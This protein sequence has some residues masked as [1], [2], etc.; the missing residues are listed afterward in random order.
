M[1]ESSSSANLFQIPNI[2]PFISIKLDGTNYLQWT[3][4]FLPILRSYDLLSIVDGSEVC[5][6]KHLVTAEG[7]QDA[8][9]AY[10]LWNKKDQ[11]VL[12]WLI[13]TLTPNV[14]ST[15]YGLNT[16]R[17]V[18]NS[19]ATRY[20]SQ[21]KSR[22]AHLK[23]Q[24]QTLRQESRTC[25]EY[26][27]LAKSWAD[28]LAAVGKPIDD[29]DLISFIISGL[30]PSYNTFIT[31]FNFA[32]RET[33]LPYDD[34]EAELLNHE[35]LLE[36]QNA[37][38]S[39]DSNTFALYSNKQ[40][41]RDRKPKFNGPQK[42]N[43][44]PKPHFSHQN[45]KPT[46][47][48]PKYKPNQS[49]PIPFNSSRPP[50][51]I[52]GK[53]N[54]QAL[55]C[56]HRMDY[57]YQGRHPPTQLA[58]M[59][60]HTNSQLVEEDHQPWYADSGANQHITADL[61]NLNLSSEPYQGNTDVAVGNGS[62]L[63]IQNTGSTTLTAQNSSFKL[64]TVLHCPDVPV[65]LLSIQKFCEENDCLFQL[66]A[67]SFLVK[68]IRTGQV[69][70]HG[71][72]RDGLYPIPLQRLSIRKARGLTAFLGIQTSASVWHHRLGHP[73]MV[74]VHRVITHNKLPITG[75]GDKTDFCESCQLA[76]C[77]RLPFTK[78][79]RVSN[80]PLQLV[81]SDVWQSPVVS[82]S[83]C[84]YYVIF[85]D[86]Y[87]RFSWLFP[88]K[89]KSDVY[90]CFI[91]FKC[92]VENLFSSKI[93]SFQSDGG[94]EYS[95]T[96]FKNL[97]TQHGIFH[98][99][100]C[101]HTSPQNGVAERKHRHVVDTGLALLAHSGLSTKYWVDAFLTAIYLI[102]RLPTPTISNQTPYYKLFHHDPDYNILR[103]FGCA[104]FPLMRPYNPHK[105]AFRSKK[106]IFLGYSSNHRGYRCLDF[107]TNRVYISRDVVFNEQDFPAKTSPSL[108]VSTENPRLEESV[109][110]PP[111]PHSGLSPPSSPPLISLTELDTTPPSPPSTTPTS[112]PPLPETTF[113]S[114][115]FEPPQDPPPTHRMIT[116]SMTGSTRPKSFR[117]HQLYYSTS[118]PLKAF[119][120]SL[121]PSEPNTYNQASKQPEWLAAMEAEFG[122]LT[123]NGTWS[124][125]PRPPNRKIIRNK[126]VFRLK[127]KADG[128]IDRYKARLVAK[129]FDQENGIDYTETFS[130][131]IKPTTIRV[132]LALAVHFNWPIRQLDVSNA[133]LHGSLTEEV[134]M[135]QPRGFVDPHFPNHVCRLH[136][137]LYGLKQAPRAW[138]TRLRQS[139]VHLG[140][141]ESLVDASLFTFHHSSIHL[142]VLIYV[143]D[144][145]VTGTHPSHMLTVIQQLQSEFPLKDLGPLSYFLGIHAVRDSHGLHLSQ[146]KYIL[147]L[148]NRARMVG[149]KPSS[150]PTASGSKLSQHAGTPLP[151]GTEYR[152][153][154]GALQYCTLTRPDIAFSV[155]QLCQFMHSPTSAHWTAAKRVLRYLK[156]TIEHG[157]SFSHSSLQ[158]TAFCDSDW[159]GNP[160]DRRSTTGF[161]IFLGSCLVSWSAKKQTVVARSST[162]AEYRAMAVT[163]ADL[164]WIRML[165]QDLH[166]PLASPPT[167]WCDNVGALAL[168][169]NPVFHA[170]TKHIEVD[171]H[172]IRE[173]VANKDMTIR[174]ISTGDQIADIFTKGLSTTRFSFLRAKL[175]V[176]PCPISLRGA[177]KEINTIDS[178]TDTAGQPA[179]SLPYIDPMSHKVAKSNIKQG[180]TVKEKQ[181]QAICQGIDSHVQKMQKIK[182]PS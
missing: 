102:N 79:D 151:D 123:T 41:N 94:G 176:I 120:S 48:F 86:D 122:A 166:V 178:I 156:G 19:L 141:V 58:A 81:H 100:S 168:A 174:F 5:P 57:S 132:I 68:D 152:Q 98:R 99:F 11:L 128:S 157:L 55:D 52:C 32:T 89:S 150:T 29:D 12:S 93:K 84:R 70:L 104:C 25:S 162:E 44:P 2:S 66:T 144:I 180:K 80:L 83:G 4:Q 77:K 10:V 158:L 53:P 31:T 131:V 161:G 14:L 56:Y 47:T 76:K 46:T 26:L 61:E 159:A 43:H 28:Q 142:Y 64:N 51:Q 1:A 96:P 101:P 147:E 65:N 82:L 63:Q 182:T 114:I 60:A 136:K 67:T 91:K 27:R 7:K 97:L 113:S 106:C 135:E 105:L 181:H 33:P 95:Y 117:D 139:L 112:L 34:F 62:G 170:R 92:M 78:S 36:N 118:H 145:L 119:H 6:A 38:A 110:L 24:L 115:P 167:L 154:I 140:F 71:L 20:A 124:L 137:A 88:L 134:Y 172:F 85:I 21:S 179:V 73:A 18:W 127:Q 116:R 155:N 16:S 121:V 175:L 108:R 23:R 107:S 148:L 15:V 72:S 173:K 164:Y 75:S 74:T 37:V 54:H 146:S 111:P 130:P 40:H 30:N 22:I 45:Q 50:C 171:Y 90:P 39:S 103:T 153:I 49:S 3:S 69:L 133:F 169:S 143:D 42:P 35:T 138:F 87:S 59:V 160:D 149:A 126:W 125:C 13:A 9:P 177:V 163:T 129:G 165:L 17:Q 109:L 8:N